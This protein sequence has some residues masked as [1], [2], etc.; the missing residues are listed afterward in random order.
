VL[1]D[2]MPN[3]RDFSPPLEKDDKLWQRDA[4]SLPVLSGKPEEFPLASRKGRQIVAA[5]LDFSSLLVPRTRGVHCNVLLHAAPCCTRR[6]PRL[7]L[8]VTAL[9]LSSF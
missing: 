2:G 4:S 7:G 5:R 1:N 8:V 6:D 3:L 9:K